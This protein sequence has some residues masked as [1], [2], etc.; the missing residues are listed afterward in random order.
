MSNLEIY[1]IAD[2]IARR[3]L[4]AITPEE[5]LTLDAWIAQ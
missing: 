2:L 1:R 5:E 3:A 4:G